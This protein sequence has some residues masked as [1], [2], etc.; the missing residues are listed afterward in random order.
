MD[1]I[2]MNQITALGAH[3]AYHSPPTSRSFL[4]RMLRLS[5]LLGL[6][7]SG[8]RLEAQGFA[9]RLS[10]GYPRLSDLISRLGIIAVELDVWKDTRGGTYQYQALVKARCNGGA[11]ISRPCW[12]GEDARSAASP[13]IHPRPCSC[14]TT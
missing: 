3:N 14:L 6:F 8:D 11:G 12:A 7:G 10:L 1:A 2:A 4:Q 9:R 5:G 13:W